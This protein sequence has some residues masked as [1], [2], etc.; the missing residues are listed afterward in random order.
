MIKVEIPEKNQTVAINGRRRL[1]TEDGC[2]TAPGVYVFYDESENVLYVGKSKDLL[3]RTNEHLSANPAEFDGRAAK[4]DYYIVFDPL[5]MDIYEAYMITEMSPEYN[6]A[7]N[8]S[9]DHQIK[10]AKEW[11]AYL[12]LIRE[13]EEDV[14]FID[15]AIQAFE[16][17]VRDGYVLDEDE[18]RELL[19]SIGERAR[20]LR[21]IAKWK[22]ESALRKRRAHTH[23]IDTVFAEAFVS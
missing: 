11:S 13:A 9:D 10:N 1:S 15:S 16:E 17:S 12:D 22:R 14:A 2:P 23:G 4:V 20:L 18:Q 6:R 21:K 7:G 19:E 5:S 8:Y 3:R